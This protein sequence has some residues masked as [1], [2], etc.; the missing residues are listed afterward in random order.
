MSMLTSRARAVDASAAAA[1]RAAEV[2]MVAGGVAGVAVPGP[3]RG[4]P[5]SA[6]W[7]VARIHGNNSGANHTTHHS[8]PMLANQESRHNR[9]AQCQALPT[10]TMR[11]LTSTCK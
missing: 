3:I 1:V 7:G 6:A 4:R 2:A 9:L 5:C 8:K 11:K 10:P